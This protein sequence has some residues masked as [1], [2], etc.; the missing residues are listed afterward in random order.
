[1]ASTVKVGDAFNVE[2]ILPPLVVQ[3]VR[4]HGLQQ[5]AGTLKFQ[6]T[7]PPHITRYETPHEDLRYYVQ[8]QRWKPIYG[9]FTFVIWVDGWTTKKSKHG[10]LQA[11]GM[12]ADPS[13]TK[14]FM[15]QNLQRRR[16][17]LTLQEVEGVWYA[18]IR[19]RDIA[20]IDAIRNRKALNRLGYATGLTTQWEQEA[21][22]QEALATGDM[23]P[24][25]YSTAG[26]T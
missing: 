26:T 4:W 18:Y 8:P 11:V 22:Y 2:V 17:G 24:E 23:P 16:G 19:F 10:A 3:A 25:P 7:H 6:P 5:A 20:R 14:L 9:G 21:W 1:M 12:W 13:H 15:Q